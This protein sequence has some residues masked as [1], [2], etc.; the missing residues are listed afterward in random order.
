MN[1]SVSGLRQK[2][3][4]YGEYLWY[5]A[6][7]LLLIPVYLGFYNTASLPLLKYTLLLGSLIG[8]CL[9]GL[10][11][12]FLDGHSPKELALYTGIFLLLGLGVV[13]SGTRA[14][15]SV[16]LLAFGAREVPFSRIAKLCLCF[17]LGVLTLNTLLVFAGVLEDTL[18]IR[19]EVWG[20][21]NVRHTLGFG[22]P[23]TLALWGMAAVFAA[24]LVF[25]RSYW[26]IALCLVLSQGLFLLTD[27]K[28]AYFSQLAAV[29]LCLLLRFL[30]PKLEG[31]KW[32]P[33]VCGGLVALVAFG[34]VALSL[35]YR[36]DSRI[37]GLLNTI[38]SQRLGYSNQGLRLFGISLFG[39]QVDFGW[40]PVDSLYTYGPICLGLV[41]SLLYLCLGVSS[42]WRAAKNGK[43]EMVAVLLAASLYC[44][45][46]YGLINPI[47]APIF[48]ACAGLSEAKEEKKP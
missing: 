11:I 46:E 10:K 7:I 38:F 15:F 27:S 20:Q 9:L 5:S 17:F 35:L 37:F 3:S 41:P 23:N 39:A 32:V 1:L 40:D 36:E 12:Y 14:L 25:T 24:L 6:L 28:A 30:G 21:G 18:L 22:Y 34:F 2:Y 44:T 13:F 42:T 31:K 8:Y 4:R 48:G 45:M 47:L 16:F 29:F 19:G 33:W 26:G 43:W